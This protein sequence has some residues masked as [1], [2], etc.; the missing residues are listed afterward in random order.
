MVTVYRRADGQVAKPVSDE[1]VARK[2]GLDYNPAIQAKGFTDEQVKKV[3]S[4]KNFCSW[5]M[6]DT[7]RKVQ[8]RF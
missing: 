1:E 5:A 7:Q 2:S 8:A 4:K 6:Q 3:V